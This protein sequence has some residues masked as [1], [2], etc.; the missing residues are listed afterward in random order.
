M[1]I[2]MNL[3]VSQDEILLLHNSERCEFCSH[4]IFFHVQGLACAVS[5]NCI[6]VGFNDLGEEVGDDDS[7]NEDEQL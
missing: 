7:A 5:D 2:E 3:D 4:S 6:C 1:K